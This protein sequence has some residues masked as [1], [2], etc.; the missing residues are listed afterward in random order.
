M[1]G[2]FRMQLSCDS[3]FKVKEERDQLG[4]D[5]SKLLYLKI[6]IWGS[7]FNILFKYEKL[8][9]EHTAD[10][11]VIVLFLVSLFEYLSLNF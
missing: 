8:H 11:M 1:K 3:V 2:D 7:F 5:Y 6:V 4:S 10:D 9:K